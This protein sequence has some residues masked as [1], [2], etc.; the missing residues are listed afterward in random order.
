MKAGI[1]AGDTITGVDG[2][3]MMGLSSDEAVN[4][5]RG[6]IDTKVTISVMRKG[7]KAPT[8]I[9]IVRK[10][11]KIP[12]IETEKKDGVFVIH[13]Y[14]FSAEA[15]D[16]FRNALND[17]MTSKLKRLVIDLRGNP[18]GYLDA[19]VNLASYFLDEGKIVVS[20]KQGK[21]ATVVNHRST[22]IVGLPKD[23]KVIVLVDGGS[24]SA[25]EILAG[26]LHDQ[27]V[28]K[29]V[30]EKSFGK[31]SVQELISL[32]GGTS[33]KV[34]IAKWYTPNGTSISEHGITP[35]VTVSFGTSTPKNKDGTLVDIQLAKAIE[36]LNAIK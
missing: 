26:A 30:G 35:D 18:G 20:E 12:T 2:K 3:S 28:A 17:L 24:A 4:K 5:I 32:P 33:L 9:V 22:G 7:L 29:V 36:L 13:V 6:E 14:N 8:D 16:A 23:I 31:G 10:E 1:K 34:T 21:D 25:S 27:G 11:I 19:A 15:P